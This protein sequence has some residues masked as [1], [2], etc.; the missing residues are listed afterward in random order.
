[1]NNNLNQRLRMM[2]NA[3]ANEARRR[4][5]VEGQNESNNNANL[6][7]TETM[8]ILERGEQRIAGLARGRLNIHSMQNQIRQ[9][10]IPSAVNRTRTNIQKLLNDVIKANKNKKGFDDFSNT[11]LF[12]LT[13][14][15]NLLTKELYNKLQLEMK[16]RNI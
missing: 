11:N 14:R 5:P 8:D 6:I 7:D 16:K 12:K 10:G 15:K 4:I 13:M 1:M 9:V 2:E 3:I